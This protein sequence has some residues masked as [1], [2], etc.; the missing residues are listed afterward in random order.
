MGEAKRRKAQGATAALNYET[1]EQV[2]QALRKL[3]IAA[4]GLLGRDCYLHAALGQA[5][6]ADFGI[7]TELVAGYA[8]WRVGEAD[9]S[10]VAHVP[11]SA[12]HLPPGMPGFA[13][14]AWLV[15]G[16]TL[17][18]FSTH[19]LRQKAKELDAADGGRTDVVWCPELLVLD[20]SQLSSYRQVAQG[21]A[22][23]AYYE[24]DEAA[25]RLLASTFSMD[26]TDL[27]MARLI[28]AQ[29]DA[30]VV[31]PNHQ[32]AHEITPQKAK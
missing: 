6:L 7:R 20:R 10:V 15:S 29:P 11:N 30:A 1:I 24:H 14:H 12:G 5:L 4:S 28:L 9:G 27:Q 22:G 13:Y 17:I 32:A 2:G 21:N 26:P 25:T 19:T 16:R 8:A 3:V 23:L 18:D 31:G